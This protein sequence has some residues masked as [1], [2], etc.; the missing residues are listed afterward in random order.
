M[1]AAAESGAPVS[2]MTSAYGGIRWESGMSRMFQYE[3]TQ[4]R[5][6]GTLWE[7]PT[8]YLENSALFRAPDIETPLLMLHNDADGAVPW[9]Q[10]IELFVALRRLQ[11]PAWMLNYNGEPHGI[12][13]RKNQKD[14]AI[15]MMQFFDHYLKGAPAPGWMTKGIA[16]TEKGKTLRYELEK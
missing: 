11:K 9:Y 8:L 5:I 10:G 2:N 4:S 13:Q 3:K 7:K 16:A 14:F 1:F 15:R 12:R 6:G